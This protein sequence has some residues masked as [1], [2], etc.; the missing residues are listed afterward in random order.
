MVKLRQV[1]RPGEQANWT[2]YFYSGELKVVQNETETDNIEWVNQLK[3]RGFEEIGADAPPPPPEQEPDPNLP[4]R[5]EEAVK[6]EEPFE[7]LGT[8]TVDVDTEI[9]SEIGEP[10]VVSSGLEPTEEDAEG[11]STDEKKPSRSRRKAETKK[12]TE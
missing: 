6:N 7:P 9:P 11:S 4:A 5:V 3:F 1:Q 8:Q 12:E 10:F 2:E